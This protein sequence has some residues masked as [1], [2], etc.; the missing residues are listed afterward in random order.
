MVLLDVVPGTLFL[1]ILDSNRYL[2]I[3]LELLES[4]PG[5]D[6]WTLY[7]VP[8]VNVGRSC[9]PAAYAFAVTLGSLWQYTNEAIVSL[10]CQDH[11]SPLV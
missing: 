5:T 7:L 2:A 3:P 8:M 11:R 6:G 10:A 9:Q 1:K 4:V